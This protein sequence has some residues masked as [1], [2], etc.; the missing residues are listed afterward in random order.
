MEGTQPINKAGTNLSNRPEA[1]ALLVELRFLRTFSSPRNFLIPVRF[2][3]EKGKEEHS[4]YDYY[5]NG[6]ITPM[7]KNKSR[8]SNIEQ[9]R[10]MIVA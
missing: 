6:A 8:T 7:T 5:E 1:E 2:L 3:S 10:S 9:Y 4:I